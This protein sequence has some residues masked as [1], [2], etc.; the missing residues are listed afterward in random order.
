MRID[1]A[2]HVPIYLQ[3]VEEVRRAI[4]MG[5]YRPG[6]MLPSQRAL[7]LQ[8]GVNPN[9]VQRAFDELEREGLAHARRGLGMFVTTR[10]AAAARDAADSRVRTALQDAIDAARQSGMPPARLRA[11]FDKL[12]SA[13][14]QP[15]PGARE[16][17]HVR[18]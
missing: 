1:P 14:E 11:M 5:V 9:T 10:G 16:T 4:A 2:D 17:S 15:R 18:R 3:I 13:D 6:E 7:A 12:L 8:L